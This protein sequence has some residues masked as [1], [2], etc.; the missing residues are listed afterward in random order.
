MGDDYYPFSLDEEMI[1]DLIETI[2]DMYAPRDSILKL[3]EQLEK[4]R[5]QISEERL[6][7]LDYD[8]MRHLEDST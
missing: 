7:R 4:R 6:N 1:L 2:E 5:D 3:K 8:L